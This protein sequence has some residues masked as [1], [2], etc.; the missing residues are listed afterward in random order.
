MQATTAPAV[1][2]GLAEKLWKQ[3]LPLLLKTTQLAPI[4]LES[5]P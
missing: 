4:N 1:V 2:A 5:K 3:A